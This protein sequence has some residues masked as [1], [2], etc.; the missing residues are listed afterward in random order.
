MHLD[1]AA[2]SR[3]SNTVIDAAATHARLEAEVG[4]YV[5]A[6]AAT[7]VL[8]AGREAVRALAGIPD[9]EV[10][11]TTGSNHAL[12]LLLSSWVGPRTLACPPGE[13]GPNLAIMAANDFQTS[14]VA[15]RSHWAGC[16][17]TKPKPCLKPTRPRWST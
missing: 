17:S 9:A 5:A 7:P 1:S 4:G 16:W 15:R 6:E 8:D 13:Y 10:V 2:C 3:Q 11:F 14:A 12:D